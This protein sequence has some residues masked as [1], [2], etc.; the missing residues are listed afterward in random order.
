MKKIILLMP[1]YNDWESLVK[2]LEEINSVIN[3]I[4]GYKFK[5]IVINDCSSV[6]K[7][8]IFK[9]NNFNS[10][11]IINMKKNRGHARCNALGLRYI[12]SKE[13]YDYV[14]IMDS[15][16]EDRPV[17]IKDLINKITE[18]PGNSVVAK[19]VKRS[20]GLIFQTL[21]NLGKRI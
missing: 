9:P 4:K 17:E 8:T 10:L 21:Y 19:R 11:K 15:D 3:N 2:L 1:V 14:I 16:G 20:E 12:N 6:E 13:S 7:P 18:N 5:C